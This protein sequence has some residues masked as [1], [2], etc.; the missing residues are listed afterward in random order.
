MDANGDLYGTTTGTVFKLTPPA[1]G[2]RWTETVVYSFAGGS[3]N[4]TPNGPLIMD[5]NGVLYGTTS[6]GGTG[7]T[8][9]CGTVFR[10]TS[11]GTGGSSWSEAVLYS[12]RAGTDGKAPFGG[13][14]MDVN[15]AL[16][17]TT[18][19]GGGTGCRGGCGTVF[20]VV[21]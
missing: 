11:P 21:P 15:G 6:G 9:G 7:C 10:L 14:I 4:V 5:A 8:K 1:A 3:D 19:S 18:A 16:Y 12:F 20:R 2:N 17:G 13:L